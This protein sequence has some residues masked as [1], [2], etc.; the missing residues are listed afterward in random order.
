MHAESCKLLG[1]ALAIQTWFCE[2]GCTGVLAEDEKPSE[3]EPADAASQEPPSSV[4]KLPGG[5][6]WASIKVC[7][8]CSL[9]QALYGYA[10]ERSSPSRIAALLMARLL[11]P[12]GILNSM[13]HA[14]CL[15]PMLFMV[16]DA[17]LQQVA[18]VQL[19]ARSCSHAGI[20][21]ILYVCLRL[22]ARAEKAA[23]EEPQEGA[24]LDFDM[25]FEQMPVAA[26]DAPSTDDQPFEHGPGQPMEGL[27]GPATEL[28]G[29]DEQNIEMQVLA[30]MNVVAAAPTED[31]GKQVCSCCFADNLRTNRALLA[32]SRWPL[33]CCIRYHAQTANCAAPARALDQSSIPT[34]RLRAAKLYHIAL[35]VM[36]ALDVLRAAPLH[37]VQPWFGHAQPA[38]FMTQSSTHRM[39]MRMGLR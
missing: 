23:A 3:A 9:P 32:E 24:N 1:A 18:F 38:A 14:A 6:D 35:P 34:L 5:F 26:E 15:S 7:R 2:P 29:E 4:S 12:D 20:L 28:T 27:E 10:A 36:H 16:V 30:L 33:E 13:L 8:P 17:L 31:V 25:A 22:Q 21:N 11:Q 39:R 37:S 19:S